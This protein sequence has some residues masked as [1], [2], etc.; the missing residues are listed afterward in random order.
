[1][2]N[3]E[4]RPLGAGEMLDRAVTLYVRW[5]PQIV[6][7]LAVVSVPVILLQALV[8]PQAAHV[9]SD[10]AQVFGS[11]G[12]AASRRAGEAMAAD[13]RFTPLTFVVMFG[14]GVVR[15]LMWSAILAVVAAAYG[16]V[17]TSLAD[18]YRLALKRWFPQ[19]VVGLTFLILGGIASIPVF[20]IYFVFAAAMVALSVMQQTV[21][22]VVVAVI[23]FL[24]VVAALGVIVSFVF[25]AYELAAVA[26]VTETGN[27]LEAVQISLRRSFARGMKRRTVVAG[28]VLML[29]SYAGTLPIVGIAIVATMLTHVDA[30]YFAIIGA[31]TV[32]LDGMVAAYA[33]VY[34][35]DVR[36]RREGYDL[37]LAPTA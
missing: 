23:A 15:V 34:A 26:V 16:G 12:S 22:V 3:T 32:L 20:A 7:V 2:L 9:W 11:T 13:S 14:A 27:P 31:G 10:M 24:V 18:A 19:I 17:R 36:V 28:L 6:L 29:L 21:A 33:V 8:A 5:F 1:M 37:L 4:L 25:M 35:V 30:L